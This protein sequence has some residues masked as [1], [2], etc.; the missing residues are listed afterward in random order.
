MKKNLMLLALFVCTMV[1]LPA[2]AQWVRNNITGV[3]SLQ[4]PN[5]KV[6]IG[7]PSPTYA[8]DIK[9]AANCSFR[10]QS[11][12]SGSSNL[13]LS[14][15][16]ASTNCLVN[17]KTGLTDLWQTGCFSGNDNFR[18]KDAPGNV[19]FQINQSNGY[20]GI[21][22]TAPET[23]F[24]VKE[25]FASFNSS[26]ATNP[27]A[28]KLDNSITIGDVSSFY[29]PGINLYSDATATYTIVY[30][31]TDNFSNRGIQ[32]ADETG[33]YA[34]VNASAFN[35][36]SDRRMK[37][38]INDITADQYPKYM[39]YIRNIESATFRYNHETEATRKVP[40]IGVIAQSLPAELQANIYEKPGMVSEPRLGVSLSEMQGLMMVGI[41]SL[42]ADMATLNSKHQNL[43]VQLELLQ[44][45]NTMLKT[46][47]DQIEKMLQS[48][49]TVT[50]LSTEKWAASSSKNGLV[51]NQPNPFNTATTIR[52][53]I[54]ESGVA[55]IVIRDLNG[56]EVKTIHLEQGKSGQ[57]IL[58]ANELKQGTY[59]YSLS[60][61]GVSVDTKLMVVTK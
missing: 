29:Y 61:N 46:R 22:T 12:T 41:K 13:I 23:K 2:T 53:N 47:L 14:R 5:D 37:K 31:I 11:T 9:Q 45:E 52:Y 19:R 51:Q 56:I 17:Y 15:S 3:T 10:I 28:N 35:V 57:V 30:G 50:T 49:E 43:K 4:F 60:I 34:E 38:E 58:N 59:T 40:H 16:V 26:R 39:E 6:G 18:I 8:L 20:V 24:Q 27:P 33:A 7:T 25:G 55:Q 44:S 54:N 42:D 48:S 32:V 1:A 36:S 21:G